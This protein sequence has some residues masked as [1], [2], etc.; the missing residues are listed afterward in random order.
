MKEKILKV[1]NLGLKVNVIS[2][3]SGYPP[4]LFA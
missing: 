3:T 1:R 2:A 4:Q